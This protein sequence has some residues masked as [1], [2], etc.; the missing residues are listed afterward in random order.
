MDTF[1]SIFT[2]INLRLKFGE[3]ELDK[4]PYLLAILHADN[5]CDT[6]KQCDHNKPLVVGEVVTVLSQPM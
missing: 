2:A 5:D 1:A 6:E 3:D 4:R